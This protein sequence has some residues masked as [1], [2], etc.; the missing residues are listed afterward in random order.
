MI[1]QLKEFLAR[2]RM[3]ADEKAFRAGFGWAMTSYFYEQMHLDVILDEAWPKATSFGGC[4]DSFDFGAR[5]AIS[6]LTR[7][8]NDR[9]DLQIA[10][11]DLRLVL[12][13][14]QG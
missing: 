10:L 4:D 1:K 2:R 13:V 8:E 5:Q 7:I 14:Q 9:R 3:S 6:E 12:A 11:S